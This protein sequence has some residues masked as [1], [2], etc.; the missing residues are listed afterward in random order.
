MLQKANTLEKLKK[1][2][3]KL[4]QNKLLIVSGNAKSGF[5][6]SYDIDLSD[7]QEFLATIEKRN[8]ICN[9]NDKLSS[10][11]PRPYMADNTIRKEN[12]VDDDKNK[13]F[14]L[15]K[16]GNKRELIPY[17]KVMWLEAEGN[18]TFIH[19]SEAKYVLKK[20]L[21]RIIEDLDDRFGQCHK[22]YCVNL[23]YVHSL[24]NN[25]LILKNKQIVPM[26]YFYKKVFMQMLYNNKIDFIK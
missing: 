16:N 2:L 23:Q 21:C 20:P 17:E 14:I 10:N 9:N 25:L 3:I 12:Q 6:T 26:S 1:A 18:Y 8:S 19:T 7:F 24:K 5:I 15:L 13:N 11:D 22:K 4:P